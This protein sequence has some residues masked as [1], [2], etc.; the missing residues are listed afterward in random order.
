MQ[1]SLIHVEFSGLLTFR[2]WGIITMGL[3]LLLLYIAFTILLIRII[4]VFVLIEYKKYKLKKSKKINGLFLETPLVI[5]ILF[6]K[7]RP[8]QYDKAFIKI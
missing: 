8:Y 4:K 7:K 6:T 3:H 1:L 2:L 5:N